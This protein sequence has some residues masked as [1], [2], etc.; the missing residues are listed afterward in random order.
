[1]SCVYVN[2]FPRPMSLRVFA[3]RTANCLQIMPCGFARIGS[4][5]DVAAIAMQAGGAAADVWIVSDKPF[6]R[7]TLLPAEG[8]V[9]R[10]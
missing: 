3:A 8:S 5:A 1:P 4:G 6:E 9:T 2:L 7:H 10:S